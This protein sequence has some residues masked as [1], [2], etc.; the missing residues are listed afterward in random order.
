V[1]AFDEK[2]V[3]KNNLKDA[4]YALFNEKAPVDIPT[5]E[6][7]EEKPEKEQVSY[8][9]AAQRVIEEFENVKKANAENNWSAFG[10][11]M[12]VLEQSINELKKSLEE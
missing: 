7:M 9:T 10:E 4:L 8:E 2:I 3:M 11:S 1:V 12:N 5:G 6:A